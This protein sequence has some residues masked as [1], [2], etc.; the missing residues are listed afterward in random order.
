MP[1]NFTQILATSSQ[2]I[3]I[4]FK[5]TAIFLDIIKINLKIIL[6]KQKKT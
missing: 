3:S 5:I 2:F 4:I 6:S 1:P